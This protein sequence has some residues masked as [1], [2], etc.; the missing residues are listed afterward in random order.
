MVNAHETGD[1]RPNTRTGRRPGEST[2]KD[3]ILA[4]ART[5]FADAGF[6]KTSIR[7]I[8]ADSGVD[9]AL[10]HH[11]FGTKRDLFV[12]AIALPIDPAEVLK[13]IRSAQLDNLGATL[14]TA[15]LQV[16]DSENGESVVAA[17]RSI[18]ADGDTDL[19]STFLL[20]IALKD[21]AQRV[22]HP[23]GSAPLRV[24]LVASQMAGVL[25]TRHVL[26]LE[27]IASMPADELVALVAP[28]LQRYLT[29]DLPTTRTSP[30]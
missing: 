22:N 19:I 7:A 29:G 15:V 3:T 26:E 20:Q 8:A 17:F 27:P 5:R 2:T 28:T 4:V 9:A 21:V 12:A 16:W 11:Y 25:L 23:V 30:G 24:N 18:I 14:A 1:R 6:D 13:P 10:V